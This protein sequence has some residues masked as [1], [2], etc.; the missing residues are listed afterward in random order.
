MG[1][2]WLMNENQIKTFAVVQT[3]V[4]HGA[5]KNGLGKHRTSLSDMDFDRYSKVG[6]PSQVS[7]H[8]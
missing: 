3:I 6:D 8:H 2:V 1:N 4:V 7:T 5:V